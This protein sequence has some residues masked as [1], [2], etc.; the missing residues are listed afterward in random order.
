MNEQHYSCHVC[1]RLGAEHIYQQVG[2]AQRLHISA[3]ALR[4]WPLLGGAPYGI[5]CLP[6]TW[7]P[8][9]PFDPASPPPFFLQDAWQ[10]RAHMQ[11]QHHACEEPDCADCLVAFATEEELKH[12]YIQRHS[13]SGWGEH[14]SRR[15]RVV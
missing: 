3:Q 11:R 2:V 10:L 7:T 12:H 6:I 15:L 13:R 9:A 4:D 1:Q 5:I 8:L 14:Q